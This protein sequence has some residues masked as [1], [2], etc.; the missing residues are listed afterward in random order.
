MILYDPVAPLLPVLSQRD[1]PA[2]CG[3]SDR[4]CV[5]YNI[6]LLVVRTCYSTSLSAN[7]D[8]ADS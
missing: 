6:E 4:S 1:M 3:I 5:S 8:E 7:H 2:I